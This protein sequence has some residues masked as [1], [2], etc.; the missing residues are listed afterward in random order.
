MQIEQKMERA[1]ERLLIRSQVSAEENGANLGHKSSSFRRIVQNR[2]IR[3]RGVWS[4]S[5]LPLLLKTLDVAIGKGFRGDGR[6]F[7]LHLASDLGH[8]RARR[9]QIGRGGE[10]GHSEVEGLFFRYGLRRGNRWCDDDYGWRRWLRRFRFDLGKSYS[11]QRRL[12]AIRVIR[13]SWSL[14][15]VNTGRKHEWRR[16]HRCRD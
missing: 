15:E 7:F 10:L 12:Q 6:L 3:G 14:A 4:R 1:V 5:R 13:G 8:I 11:R 2:A 9:I 16:R